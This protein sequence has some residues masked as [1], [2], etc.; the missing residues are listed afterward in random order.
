MI[1]KKQLFEVSRYVNRKLK[2][3]DLKIIRLKLEKGS[4][5]LKKG[6]PVPE[7]SIS[8][9]SPTEIEKYLIKEKSTDGN[10]NKK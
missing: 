4:V 10:K 6:E 2:S 1:P 8:I 9:F 5:V 3:V 7:K